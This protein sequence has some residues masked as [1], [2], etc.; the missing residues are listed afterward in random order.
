MNEGVLRA[1]FERSL[2][3]MLILDDHGRYI[4]ANAA[5]CRLFGR[6]HDE[7]LATTF[8]RLSVDAAGP[9]PRSGPRS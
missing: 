1:A 4:D 3:G 9:C 6:S 2:D 7:I 5:A 8:H